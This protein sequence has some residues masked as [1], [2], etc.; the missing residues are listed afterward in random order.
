MAR[1]LVIDDD[2]LLRGVLAK[3]LS[4]RGH[5]ITEAADGKEGVERARITELD[6]V[7]TDLVMPVQEGL[8]TIVTLRREQPELPVIAMS[9]GATNS[10]LYLEIAGKIGARRI[11]PKPFTPKRLVELIDEILAAGSPKAKA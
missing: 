11:L 1:I 4:L 3:A 9:G 10:K 6:L 2:D 7:I 5:T 8:E